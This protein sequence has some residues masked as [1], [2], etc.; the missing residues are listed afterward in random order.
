MTPSHSIEQFIKGY[1]Q[2]RLKAFLP[3]PNDVPTIGWGRTRGVR[4]GMTQTQAQADAD[5]AADLVDRSAALTKMLAG[6]ATT[7]DQFDAMLSLAYNIGVANFAGS[8]VLTNHKAQHYQTA[9]LAFRLWCKQR[10]RRTHELEVLAGLVKRR[11]A[12]ALIYGGAK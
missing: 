2:C 8:S 9:A 12:E 3:T 5:F 11:A 6:A 1:E 4:M 7:Q 10:N